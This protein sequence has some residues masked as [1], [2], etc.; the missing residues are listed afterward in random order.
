MEL[1]GLQNEKII[2]SMTNIQSKIMEESEKLN[3]IIIEG[4]IRGVCEEIKKYTKE[5]WEGDD[6][7]KKLSEGL[8]ELIKQETE[9]TIND[10]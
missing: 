8:I 7:I 10:L 2:S 4:Y 3:Q 5:K 9:K 6:M 1:H